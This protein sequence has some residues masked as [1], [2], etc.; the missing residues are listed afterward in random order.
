MN[1]GLI[2]EIEREIDH[3]RH[4]LDRTIRALQFELSPRHQL[5]QAWRSAKHRTERSVR[6]GTDWAKANPASLAVGAC[7]LVAAA[8]GVV[9]FQRRH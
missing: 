5:E 1:S 9:V 4:A 7:V 6:A 2:E 8:V 3:T